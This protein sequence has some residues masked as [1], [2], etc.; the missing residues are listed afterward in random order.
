MPQW[1]LTN[2]FVGAAFGSGLTVSHIDYIRK[3]ARGARWLILLLAGRR[4]VCNK[5]RLDDVERPRPFSRCL[6]TNI[7]ICHTSLSLL[8]STAVH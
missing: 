2:I 4:K 7:A 5:R 8:I 1:F 6:T 3:S